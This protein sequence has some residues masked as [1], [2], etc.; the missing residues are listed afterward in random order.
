MSSG[1]LLVITIILLGLVALCVG[2]MLVFAGNKFA[3]AVDPKESA[4]RECL[5][6]N[7]CGAC[8]YPGCDG[9]QVAFVRCSGTCDKA[10]NNSNYV[11]IRSCSAAAAIPGKGEKLCQDGCLGFGECVAQCDFDAI[12]IVDGIAYVDRTK[13]VGCGK[14]A[15]ACPQHLIEIIPD[16]A[17]YAVACASRDKGKAVKA[18][19]AAGC[20]GCRG[21][22]IRC[23]NGA[24]TFANN[25]AHIDYSQC[26][27]ARIPGQCARY[28]QRYHG[29]PERKEGILGFC[30][31][32]E[33]WGVYCPGP[34]GRKGPHGPPVQTRH[35]KGDAGAAGRRAGFRG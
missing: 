25:L 7:N 10:V 23:K 16:T 28:L 4:V 8:G 21:C 27:G 11:G 24:M 26:T 35:R 1:A 32:Q 13:C 30:G 34:P 22:V 20:I 17:V 15:K 29:A 2:V 18:Q 14:C 31:S 19:C 12:H 33:G 5:P 3:V 9:R 6:G